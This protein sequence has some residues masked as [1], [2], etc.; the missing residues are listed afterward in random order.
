MYKRQLLKGIKTSQRAL[1]DQHGTYV[2]VAVKISPDMAAEDIDGFC[3][4]ATRNRIDGI[5]AG[6]TTLIRDGV[7]ASA[8]AKEAGGLSGEPLT[9]R[10][11]ATIAQLAQRLQ[12]EIPIIG[13]GG[14]ASGADAAA[15]LA[16]GADLVQVY[17]GFIFQGPALINDI[18]KATTTEQPN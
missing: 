1:A 7:A 14:I 15:H 6:N 8:H 2:P 10:A 16:A 4:A 9:D 3:D 12:G 18:R 5:I 13:C 17:T 11:R